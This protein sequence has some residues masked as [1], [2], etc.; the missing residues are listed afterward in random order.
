[1]GPTDY[2]EILLQTFI[3]LGIFIVIYIVLKT[4]S[5]LKK[6]KPTS[7][8]NELDLSVNESTTSENELEPSTREKNRYW[9]S[10]SIS[11]E[12]E[13]YIYGRLEDKE[14][15]QQCLVYGEFASIFFLPKDIDVLKEALS[16]YQTDLMNANTIEYLYELIGLN[17]NFKQDEITQVEGYSVWEN[18]ALK[19][20]IKDLTETK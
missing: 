18:K 19:Q 20:L 12:A 13:A 5:A 10:L 1:M 17:F 3:W 16:R 14:A 7:S 9:A 2:V 4:E 15:R 11:Y 6:E 8:S